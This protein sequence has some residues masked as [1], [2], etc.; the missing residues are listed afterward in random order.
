MRMFWTR[1]Q[2]IFGRG[3]TLSEQ[4]PHA[5]AC[6]ACSKC[7]N[8]SDLTPSLTSSKCSRK[9]RHDSQMNLTRVSASASMPSTW[10]I[11]ASLTHA[12]LS[13]T[14]PPCLLSSMLRNLFSTAYKQYSGNECKSLHWSSAPLTP[15]SHTTNGDFEEEL[16]GLASG[17]HIA[18]NAL[19]QD[20]PSLRKR[21]HQQCVW[22][23]D[24]QTKSLKCSPPLSSFW[25]THMAMPLTTDVM[26]L[27]NFDHYTCVPPTFHLRSAY[28][29]YAPLALHRNDASTRQLEWHES[30]QTSEHKKGSTTKHNDPWMA[31]WQ[32]IPSSRVLS[33]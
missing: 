23:K 12:Q 5:R 6:P 1:N 26:P 4:C 30:T 29:P 9:I 8:S 24:S 27:H 16:L 33:I 14:P 22:A 19:A 17:N 11:A 21:G 3:S 2:S 31:P 15:W 7:L 10:Q 25:K 32:S 18:H 28:V 13:P 20:A